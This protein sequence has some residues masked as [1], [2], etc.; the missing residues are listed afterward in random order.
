MKKF[1]YAVV[2]GTFDHLHAGHKALLKAAKKSAKRLAVGL[3]K[4]EF[5]T[6]KLLASLIEPFAVRHKQLKKFL[7]KFPAKIVPL[8]DPI[9]PAATTPDYDA[10]FASPETMANVNKI[11]RLRL[12][13]GLKPLKTVMIK[14]IKDS[15]GQIIS[16]SRIRAGLI[17]RKGLAYESLFKHRLKLP[18]DQRRHF[19]SPLGSIMTDKKVVTLIKKQKPILTIAVGDIAVMTLIQQ[20][21]TPDL[22]IIDLKTKRR[23]FVDKPQ[24]L[25][26]K[27]QIGQVV[28][29]PP[30]TITPSLVKALLKSF[31]KGQL[32][33]VKGEEDLAVLPAAL[34][35]PLTSAVIYGQPD[36][37][38]VYLIV[39]EKLKAKI[40]KL[41]HKFRKW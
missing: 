9:G 3:T 13:S 20:G 31:K 30:G 21:L 40:V 32:I 18:K 10:I 34:L 36:R 6:Q 37:G 5:I 12:K 11:N 39:T 23:L 7:G 17:D 38:L 16:S 24:Q 8:K 14:P 4:P 2:A 33:L 27:R 28:I 25:G 1:N 19:K 22:A 29:N 26:L 15:A 35:A 41:L